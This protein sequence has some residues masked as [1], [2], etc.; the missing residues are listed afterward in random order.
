[1]GI[2][3]THTLTRELAKEIIDKHL[4]NLNDD[5]LCNILEQFP[6]SYDRNYKIIYDWQKT[7]INS[8]EDFETL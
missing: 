8:L 5:S 3:S 4:S 2:K 7:T 6:Q 1:M